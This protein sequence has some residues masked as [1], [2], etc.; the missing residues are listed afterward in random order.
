[1]KRA[2]WDWEAVALLKEW[3]RSP[4]ELTGLG[5][6]VKHVPTGSWIAFGELFDGYVIGLD[7]NGEATAVLAAEC[8][9]GWDPDVDPV[10]FDAE[11]Q[12]R[13]AEFRHGRR[14]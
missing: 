13:K 3:K 14:S 5:V 10:L 1:M 7:D 12:K 2:R 11:L 9:L 8:V 4:D 6:P